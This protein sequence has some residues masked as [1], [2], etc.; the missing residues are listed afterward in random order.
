MR[1]LFWNVQRLGRTTPAGKIDFIS[2][3]IDRAEVQYG[4]IDHVV[5]CEVTGTAMIRGQPVVRELP[6]GARG[7]AAI[8]QLAYSALYS[9]PL[10]AVEIADFDDVFDFKPIYK[11]GKN[12]RRIAMRNVG[13]LHNGSGT[14]CYV[15]HA[16]ASAVAARQV[17]WAATSLNKEHMVPP[18]PFLL[19]GDLNCT[20]VQLTAHLDILRRAHRENMQAGTLL[21]QVTGPPAGGFGRAAAPAFRVGPI[22]GGAGA[23]GAAAAAG[24][25]AGPAAGAAAGPAAGG[26]AQNLRPTAARRPPPDPTVFFHSVNDP[27]HNAA[28]GNPAHTYDWAIGNVHCQ[29]NVITLDGSW[30]HVI[31]N[32]PPGTYDFFTPDHYPILI[33]VT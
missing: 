4:Q 24:A 27:T 16:N 32:A 13:Q 14:D 3:V 20:P 21:N 23:W 26:P 33:N 15:F 8:S 25:G 18:R 19:F 22:G 12:F 10:T 17:A 9:P 6:V 28:H 1:I 7:P 2:A 5:F 11:H 29:F 31:A 30:A